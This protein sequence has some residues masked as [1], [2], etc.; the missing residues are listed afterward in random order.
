MTRRESTSSAET[1]AMKTVLQDMAYAL[2]G[3]RFKSVQKALV[4]RS[5]GYLSIGGQSFSMAVA[6]Q[7]S[8]FGMTGKRVGHNHMGD[9]CALLSDPVRLRPA[10]GLEYLKRHRPTSDARFYSP[11]R[12]DGSA[13]VETVHFSDRKTMLREC[14]GLDRGKAD[15]QLSPLL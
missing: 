14:G 4:C 15:T 8:R 5:K 10:E 1:D 12:C 2:I 7:R 9:P 3:I 6:G 13:K 11:P